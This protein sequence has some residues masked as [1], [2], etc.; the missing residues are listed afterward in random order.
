MDEPFI[1]TDGTLVQ[2]LIVEWLKRRATAYEQKRRLPSDKI[3]GFFADAYRE[4]AEG[5]ENG[6]WDGRDPMETTDG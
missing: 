4:A 2:G 6:H 5:V 3:A 1:E